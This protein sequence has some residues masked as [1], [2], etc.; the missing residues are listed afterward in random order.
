MI[1]EICLALLILYS[2]ISQ[3]LHLFSHTYEFGL[4]HLS[5][6]PALLDE[7][8]ARSL[9]QQAGNSSNASAIISETWTGTPS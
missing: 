9:L 7:E 1:L 2:V 8:R 6:Y 3:F 5:E 4:R